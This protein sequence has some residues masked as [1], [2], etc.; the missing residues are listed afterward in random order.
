M[1]HTP[2]FLVDMIFPDAL[3]H[4]DILDSMLF[5]SDDEVDIW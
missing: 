1:K 2:S 3:P 5:D 4:V